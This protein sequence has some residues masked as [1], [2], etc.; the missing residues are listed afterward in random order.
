MSE[1]V[2]TRQLSNT[3]LGRVLEMT[4]SG[5]SKLRNG[6][7]LPSAETVQKIVERLGGDYAELNAAIV[8]HRRDRD[9]LGWSALIERLT[10]VPVEEP[11]T[12]QRY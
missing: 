12:T 8:A 3:E 7:A 10:T 5:A 6:N 9:E 2:R 11:T 4:P 1:P